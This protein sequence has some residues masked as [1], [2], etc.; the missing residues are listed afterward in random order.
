L[1]QAYLANCT[2]LADACRSHIVWEIC[3]KTSGLLDTQL[4]PAVSTLRP[5]GRSIIVC[6]D[7]PPACF[8]QMAAM[9]VHAMG[10][11]LAEVAGGEREAMRKLEL[12]A[13]HA[14]T[15]RMRAIAHDC[16]KVS[17]TAAAICAGMEY[18]DGDA[19]APLVSD[20]AE[21][22]RYSLDDVYRPLLNA[23]ADPGVGATEKKS[24][25]NWT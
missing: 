13:A 8:R 10:L 2:N 17:V 4:L 23:V 24:P 12:L 6:G 15:H 20:P 22:F 14:S 18:L 21:P 11:N 5:Y 7:L 9:G 1:R 25:G 3:A 16:H 19:I